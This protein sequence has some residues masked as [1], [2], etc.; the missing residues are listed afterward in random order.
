MNCKGCGKNISGNDYKK[1]A[2]WTFCMA[3]FDD[4]MNRSE[5]KSEPARTPGIDSP[6]KETCRICDVEIDKGNGKKLGIWTL[7]QACHN[8]MTFRPVEKPVP[9]E[10]EG[11]PEDTGEKTSSDNAGERVKINRTIPCSGCGR[12]ILE[13]AAKVDQDNFYC[14]DCF[15]KKTEE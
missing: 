1:V 14:P 15:Y 12:S 5:Q 11:T 2:D 9:E 10:T 3:C 13:V 6:A 7:C 8:D 4:L